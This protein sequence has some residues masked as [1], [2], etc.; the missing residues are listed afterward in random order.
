MLL[1]L[2]LAAMGLPAAPA[3]A[4]YCYVPENPGGPIPL[5][6]QPRDDAAVVARMGPGSMIRDVAG[7]ARRGDWVRLSWYRSQQDRKPAARGWARAG[8]IH[9]G[10]CED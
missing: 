2:A 6:A 3:R 9:G 8:E 10:E 1:L 4:F 5:R 7:T